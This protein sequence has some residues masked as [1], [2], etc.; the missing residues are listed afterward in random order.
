MTINWDVVCKHIT[1]FIVN[2]YDI[3]VISHLTF[4]L[5]AV[6]VT[7]RQVSFGEYLIR[8][9]KRGTKLTTFAGLDK[10]LITSM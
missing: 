6:N 4:S 1:M 2:A 9:L 3:R 7:L 5:S 10:I 8:L